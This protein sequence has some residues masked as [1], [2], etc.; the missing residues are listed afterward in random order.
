MWWTGSLNV[1]PARRAW[2]ADVNGDG[3]TDLLVAQD[4][5]VPDTTPTGVHFAV[6]FSAPAA[7]AA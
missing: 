1:D 3:A 6:A 4:V 7:K 2:A 5:S